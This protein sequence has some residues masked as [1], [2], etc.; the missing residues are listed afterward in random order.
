MALKRNHLKVRRSWF[1]RIWAMP[2]TVVT[3]CPSIHPRRI[4]SMGGHVRFRFEG[5]QGCDLGPWPITRIFSRYPKATL[6]RV[7]ALLLRVECA[8]LAI[9]GNES[10]SSGR[11]AQGS[12]RLPGR[13]WLSGDPPPKKR[14][15]ERH[16]NGKQ[17][18]HRRDPPRRDPGG[19]AAREPR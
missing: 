14:A 6:S 11:R 2:P 1:C 16:V 4:G 18:A 8:M 5:G 9:I 10:S 13:A 17:D 15:A 19:R 12:G 7:A 3:N